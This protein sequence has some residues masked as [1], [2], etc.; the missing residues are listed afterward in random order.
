M[1]SLR[2]VF[3]M[4]DRCLAYTNP[5]IRKIK[6]YPI[7]RFYLLKSTEFLNFRH[8]RHFEILGISTSNFIIILK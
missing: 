8:F 3:I 5:G 7:L 6:K 1:V 2:S 4:N